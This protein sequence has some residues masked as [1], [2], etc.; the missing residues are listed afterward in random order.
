MTHVLR[1]SPTDF[2]WDNPHDPLA[3]LGYVTF[4]C[5]T[6]V[7]DAWEAKFPRYWVKYG[8]W[9][10]HRNIVLSVEKIAERSIAEQIQKHILNS[11]EERRAIDELWVEVR[12]LGRAPFEAFDTGAEFW[13]TAGSRSGQKGSIVIRSRNSAAVQWDGEPFTGG[14]TYPLDSMSSTPP[15]PNHISHS[16]GWLK[17]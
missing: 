3:K 7:A 16:M 6:P 10:A 17:G 15:G 4:T 8:G 13:A 12:D 1:M 2:W 14:T 5:D 9:C 11:A